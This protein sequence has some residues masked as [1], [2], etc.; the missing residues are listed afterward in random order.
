MFL[1]KAAKVSPILKEDSF[2]PPK[3][4]KNPVVNTKTEAAPKRLIRI[5]TG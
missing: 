3:P 5:Y 2:S 1:Y 4:S